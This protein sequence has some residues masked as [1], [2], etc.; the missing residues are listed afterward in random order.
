MTSYG[1]PKKYVLQ[2]KK[3]T[4]EIT[5]EEFDKLTHKS[6]QKQKDLVEHQKKKE[7]EDKFIITYRTPSREHPRIKHGPVMEATGVEKIGM[8]PT[9]RQISILVKQR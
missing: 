2:T 1:K 3:G 6:P 7:M 5:K 4:V 9:P 8:Y